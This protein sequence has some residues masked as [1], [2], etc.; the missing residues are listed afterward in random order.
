MD[1]LSSGESSK[2][3]SPQKAFLMGEL[4]ATKRALTQKEE[5]MRQLEERLQRL[6]TKQTRQPRGRRWDQRRI[7]RSY[8]HYGSQ[9]EEQEW[10]MHQY[11]E[12][13]H[14]HQPSKPSFPFIKLPSFNGEND[15]NVY[16]G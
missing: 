1:N 15:P 16:L 11:G 12:R 9:E 6:E 13:R 5:D 7:S 10:R 8:S 3:Q 14:P 4:A 2:P